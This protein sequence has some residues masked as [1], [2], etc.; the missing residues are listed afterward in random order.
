MVE[1]LGISLRDFIFY[2]VNFLIL[3]FVLGKFLYKPF[4]NALKDRKQTIKSAMENAEMTN[5]KADEKM[6]N[7]EKKIARVESESKEIIRSA[8]LR[9]ETQ[10][11]GIIEEAQEKAEEILQNARRE[12][13][14]EK[15]KALA[16]MREEVGTLAM[17]AAEKIM[18]KEIEV[19]GQDQI[20]DK[21]IEEAG[22]GEW[23]N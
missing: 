23:Q 5:R 21:V 9:A 13:E 10:A 3:V 2:M 12:I 20:I 22:A 1:A 18:E 16:D 7:Y 11:N 17:L 4:V 19:N 6:A 15:A 8:R 14:R